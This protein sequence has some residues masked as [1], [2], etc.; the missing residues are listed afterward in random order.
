[1]I[2][3]GKPLLQKNFLA[4]KIGAARHGLLIS[5][6]VGIDADPLN[7]KGEFRK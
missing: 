7:V 1:M 6:I 4:D 2:E 5:K 3:A